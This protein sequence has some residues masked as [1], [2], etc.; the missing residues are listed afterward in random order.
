MVIIRITQ[1]TQAKINK[2]RYLVWSFLV[3]FISDFKR[4]W[5]MFL[6]DSSIY[7]LLGIKKDIFF[8]N[9]HLKPW[10]YVFLWEI[11]TTRVTMSQGLS[12]GI[13]RYCVYW[14]Q[15]TAFS[16]CHRW[17]LT[18]K[19][20]RLFNCEQLTSCRSS[21]DGVL[22]SIKWILIFSICGM[23]KFFELFVIK[24]EWMSFLLHLHI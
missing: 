3:I 20:F 11:S 5:K 9:M 24:L 2:K 7:F 14:L 1:C 16:Q 19:F 8:G 18:S 13:G 21:R 4:L 10:N 17:G 6:Q 22:C 23:I 15:E 12:I